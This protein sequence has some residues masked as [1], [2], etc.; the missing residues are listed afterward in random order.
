MVRISTVEHAQIRLDMLKA[1]QMAIA[2]EALQ[3][4]MVCLATHA[5]PPSRAVAVLDS[6]WPGLRQRLDSLT[7]SRK[8]PPACVI[9]GGGK[10]ANVDRTGPTSIGFVIGF[11]LEE[12]LITIPGPGWAPTLG[13]SICQIRHPPFG[14]WPIGEPHISSSKQNL[15]F[16]APEQ[17]ATESLV[18][19]DARSLGE[20]QCSDAGGASACGRQTKA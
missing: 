8:K 15:R 16:S 7:Q 17:T 18:F 10:A 14:P 9:W 19:A 2:K 13:E 11:G 4:F 1:W 6:R 12:T 3:R 20:A 5:V